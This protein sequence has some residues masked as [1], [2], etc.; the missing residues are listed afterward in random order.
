VCD[1]ACEIGLESTVVALDGEGIIILRP[2]EV[3]IEMLRTM[4][5]NV[6]FA[7]HNS[8]ASP[9]SPGTKYKHYAPRAKLILVRGNSDNVS[10][11]LREKVQLDG[12]GVI[13]SP[14]ADTL[15]AEL[16]AF[17]EMSDIHMIY[18]PYPTEIALEN[19]LLKAAQ[20]NIIE[21]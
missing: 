11:F 7:E 18:A 6:R 15:F 4:S 8:T 20:G 13:E 10:A 17:D 12:V 21:I 16:R 3:T 1:G 5:E 19:R 9:I 2:G 14:K